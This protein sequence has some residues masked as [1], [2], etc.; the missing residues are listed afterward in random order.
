MLTVVNGKPVI[1][2]NSETMGVLVFK[3]VNKDFAREMIVNNHYSHKWCSNFGIVNIGIFRESDPTTCLG[4]ASYG[5]MMHPNSYDFLASNVGKEEILEL[6]RLWIDDCLGKNAETMLLSASFKIL[7]WYGKIKLIQTFADGRLG[8]GTIYKASNFK[9]YGKDSTIFLQD[10]TDGLIYFESMFTKTTS[11]NT[12]LKLGKLFYEDKMNLFTVNTYRYLY[13]LDPKVNIILKELPYPEYNKGT[14]PID[15]EDIWNGKIGRGFRGALFRD[16]LLAK[17]LKD[18][19]GQK[20]I[21]NCLLQKY[22]TDFINKM[23]NEQKENEI[24]HKKYDDNRDY[25]QL[26]LIEDWV[27]LLATDS[28]K[29]IIKQP[30]YVVDDLFSDIFK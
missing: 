7:K 30:K 17:I 23:F 11:P 20:I 4:V 26:L 14:E 8:C 25:Q 5:W 1:T 10:K 15:P 19:E 16:Y 6:N 2:K 3:E 28:V 24:L 12:M 13:K 18:D 27:S 29:E 22:P 21:A 9:Y